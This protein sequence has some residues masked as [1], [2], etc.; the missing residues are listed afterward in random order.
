MRF[1]DAGRN[2]QLNLSHFG[3]ILAVM[4]EKELP[5]EV[6]S[7]YKL[8]GT[9]T[10]KN[11][12]QKVFTYNSNLKAIKLQQLPSSLINEKIFPIL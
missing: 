10:I 12:R 11:T 7:T 3:K 5:D 6:T 4:Q 9:V 2:N 8:Q 1:R